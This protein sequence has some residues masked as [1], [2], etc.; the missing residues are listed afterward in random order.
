MQAS[1]S[2]VLVICQGLNAH[3]DGRGVEWATRNRFGP[4]F[5][6]DDSLLSGLVPIGSFILSV[7]DGN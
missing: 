7:P 5:C 2:S 6:S 1:F 3:P 4:D